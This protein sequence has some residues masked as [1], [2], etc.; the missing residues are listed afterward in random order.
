MKDV[1]CK[2]RL[3]QRVLYGFHGEWFSEKKKQS[4]RPVESIRRVPILE[5]T[6]VGDITEH[7]NNWKKY[8]CRYE[9]GCF[10]L[11]D[12]D[13]KSTYFDSK[14]GRTYSKLSHRLVRTVGAT[15]PEFSFL[16]IYCTTF[17]RAWYMPNSCVPQ[18]ARG[19]D[20][21]QYMSHVGETRP[22]FHFWNWTFLVAEYKDCYFDELLRSNFE[23][24]STGIL[25]SNV[26]SS[27]TYS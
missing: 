23:E 10:M 6:I 17:R 22:H 12:D 15:K 16:Y 9:I 25:V 1:L 5:N 7:K 27:E 2:V 4:R 20:T 24:S 8:G 13:W 26:G 3:P 19:R 21:V 18:I 11:L 14:F